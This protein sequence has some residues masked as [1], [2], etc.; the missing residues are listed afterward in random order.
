MYGILIG[1]EPIGE[2]FKEILPLFETYSIIEQMKVHISGYE[3]ISH[4]SFF[5]ESDLH[6][7]SFRKLRLKFRYWLIWRIIGIRPNL[8][9]YARKVNPKSP[10]EERSV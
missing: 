1:R 4:F 9:S 10:N 6:V 5:P 8:Q 3:I 2:T 7:C